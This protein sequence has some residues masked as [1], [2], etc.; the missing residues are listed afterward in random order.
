[1]RRT[2]TASDTRLACTNLVARL[3][4]RVAEI[5][6]VTMTRVV[7][8][9]EPLRDN[10]EYAVGLREAVSAAI[11]HG[12]VSLESR[13]PVSVPAATVSQARLAARMDVPLDTVLRRYFAGYTLLL[14]FIM[15]EARAI[16]LDGLQLQELLR[17]QSLVH[18]RVVAAV[19]D[20]YGRER[21]LRI[22]SEAGRRASVVRRL[23]AGEVLDDTSLGYKFDRY[24]HHG[25]VVCGPGGDD[26][27][28][29]LAGRR[30]CRALTVTVAPGVTWA[31]LGAIEPL[32][33]KVLTED[34][35]TLGKTPTSLAI[36]EPAPGMAGWRLTHR[37]AQ[38]AS[39]VA[40]RTG[41][42]AVRYSDVALVASVLQD[43]VL[44]ASL[45]A[46]Y[47]APLAEE[48]DGGEAARRTLRAYFGARRNVS[49][50]AAALGVNRQT[51]SKRLRVIDERL[52]GAL[53]SNGAAL[54]TA[55]RL[56][57]LPFDPRRVVDRVEVEVST[58]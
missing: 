23:L 53:D 47:I 29:D 12:L 16:G 32:D 5:E 18:E 50:A 51:V 19:S 1:M 35:S 22:E 9:A 54:E 13:P 33:S 37:Q 27:V 7:A 36:G 56:A 38:A 20:E 6:A 40:A 49:S 3:R 43:E 28:R 4:A 25:L 55:L 30:D 24:H 31:W 2:A 34:A 26:A 42:R 57:D 58:R 10:P 11:D 48:R 52:G 44:A 41:D 39:A 21:R 15:A 17:A 45:D 8:I 46:M 14:D